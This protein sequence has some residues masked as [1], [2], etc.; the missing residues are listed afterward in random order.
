MKK[1]AKEKNVWSEN[2]CECGA[3]D[4]KKNIAI[5]VRKKMSLRGIVLI[6][7]PYVWR[8]REEIIF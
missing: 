4:E 6:T 7:P 8:I 2:F 3:K 5:A 1:D